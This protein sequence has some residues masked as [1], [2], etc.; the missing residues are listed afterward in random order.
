M[1]RYLTGGES[2][3]KSLVGILEGM[4]A[5]LP[6][7]IEEINHQLYRR[8]QGHGRGGRMKI[9]KDKVMILSGIRF[10]E[11]TGSPISVEVENKDWENWQKRMNP[12]N[13]EEKERPDQITIPRPGH[14]DLAGSV[15]YGHSDIRNIIE[16]ASARETAV[17]TALSGITRQFLSEFGIDIGSHVV[18]IQKVKSNAEFSVNEV[19]EESKRADNSPVRS[20]DP[21]AESKMISVIDE[22]KENGDTVGGR[23]E[24]V[25]AEMPVGLGSH[26]QW[27]RRLDGAIAGAM[28]AI[29]AIKAVEI[30]MGVETG[31]RFGS[32]VHDPIIKDVSKNQIKRRSNNAGGIEG[33]ISNGQPVIVYITMKPIST[34]LSALDSVDLKSREE[35]KARVERSDICAVPA[36][37]IVGEAV[38]SLVLAK[39]FLDKF[40]G[41]HIKDVRN[42]FDN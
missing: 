38:L 4:P 24:I 6:I 30:G 13:I 17:R 9:E 7:N 18:E 35:V 21:E 27:D 1:L 25:A 39:A 12:E 31:R 14:A 34:L 36:A 11:T 20:L 15:K 37:S 22:A 3:G 42:A 19:L 29:P 2:H 41:D 16:R 5:G 32:K 40:G 8:Q 10:G 33:G 23:I 26:T 28:M